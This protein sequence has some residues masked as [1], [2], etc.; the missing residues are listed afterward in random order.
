MPL[1][2]RRIGEIELK[3]NTCFSL[4]PIRTSFCS[5][6]GNSVLQSEPCTGF[7]LVMSFA[8]RVFINLNIY[9]ASLSMRLKY[10]THD[11]V[12]VWS[13]L[14]YGIFSGS[15]K[16]SLKWEVNVVFCLQQNASVSN[17]RP[18]VS[19][20]IG[21]PAV[22]RCHYLIES[23]WAIQHCAQRYGSVPI[24]LLFSPR[25]LSYSGDSLS[26]SLRK[27]VININIINQPC[28]FF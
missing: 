11:I 21:I 6:D 10:T 17:H 9:R 20:L 19:N 18:C 15:L 16:S 22:K 24:P 4:A 27:I 28:F 26:S 1:T 8:K 23:M 14:L 2:V 25:W 13:I 3:Q 5:D 7:I 12:P